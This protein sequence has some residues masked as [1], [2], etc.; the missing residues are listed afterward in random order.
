MHLQSL[1]PS[2][3]RYGYPGQHNNHGHLQGK[4]KQIRYQNAPE[5]ADEGV[6]SGKRNQNKDAN[7]H[8]RISRI[9]QRVL[10]NV[11]A[12]GHLQ[13]P[14]LS[15]HGSEQNRDNAD[16]G[17][18]HPSQDEAVHEKAEINSFESAQKRRWFSPVA[19]LDQLDV[20][21]HLSPA[22]IACEEENRHHSADAGAPPDPI[23]RDALPGN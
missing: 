17:L 2:N 21:Q 10:K 16:H 19:K 20:G 22:P 14:T 8:R 3:L 9:A 13:H 7:Q 15:N 11:S 6:E 1:H 18:R 23:A 12:D 4:L 5:S